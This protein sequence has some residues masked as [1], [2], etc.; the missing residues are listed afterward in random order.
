M[1]NGESNS[2]LTRS[3]GAAEVNGS[4]PGKNGK[5]LLFLAAWRLRVRIAVVVGSRDAQKEDR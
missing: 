1:N 3:R 2:S 4:L 5:A